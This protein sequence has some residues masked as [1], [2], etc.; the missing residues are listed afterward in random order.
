MDIA[1]VEKIA[2]TYGLCFT[3]E[4]LAA[5]ILPNGNGAINCYLWLQE[6]FD[7][8]GDYE[9]NKKEI[10]LDPVLKD[11]VHKEYVANLTPF[12]G[13]KVILQ[14]SEFV[15]TWN[16]YF[17]HVKI[18]E[19]KACSGKC[20]LCSTFSVLMTKHKTLEAMR[21]VKE[22]RALHRKDYMEDRLLYQR[23][24]NLALD[25]PDEH[26]SIIS[27][28]MQQFHTELPYSANQITHNK[29]VKQHLQGLTTH[30]RRTRMYRTV[31]HIKLGANLSIYVLLLALDEELRIAGK[32]P[33]TLYLQIDGGSENANWSFLAWMEILIWMDV[34]IM[35]IWV[36]RMKV[37]HTHADQDARFGRVWLKARDR[38]LLSPQHYDS[39]IVNTLGDYPGGAALVD[40]FVIPDLVGAVEDSVDS[41]LRWAFRGDHTQLVFRF[42]KTECSKRFP[43]GSK[44]TY[45]ASAL[46]SFTE[47]IE[48]GAKS[49]TGLAPRKV[50]CEWHPD[51]GEGMSF[52]HKVP[53]LTHIAPQPF[54]EGAL[55]ELYD[56]I[57]HIK[58]NKLVR[59]SPSALSNWDKFVEQL[60]YRHESAD[61]FVKRKGMHMP[62]LSNFSSR[63]FISS[64]SLKSTE[65]LNPSNSLMTKADNDI[66][67]RELNYFA[68][69]VYAGATI[70]WRESLK[71][72]PPRVTLDTRE[73]AC[74]GRPS[75]R[76][77][78]VESWIDDLRAST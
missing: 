27:D 34:G 76:F 42:E 65:N 45:R 70:R 66:K 10:H 73:N 71:P 16:K 11:E 55:N 75:K 48:E 63:L 61:A 49:P 52:L 3:E 67:T 12:K 29:K 23:R 57:A 51:S 9:P 19:Y 77:R 53:E 5:T 30:G 1:E 28:G 32:L 78:A 33:K 54:I 43:M 59:L 17:P 68:P 14:H 36:C 41:E 50:I 22:F 46:D 15:K 40:L 58:K 74:A 26:L 60:P 35:E 21:H 72:E 39:L 69:S 62:F 2:S 20:E 47:F 7:A 4:E 38:Y 64:A 6:Y 31:D 13:D 24:V 18:R 56:S 44:C 25:N 8:C 37:G